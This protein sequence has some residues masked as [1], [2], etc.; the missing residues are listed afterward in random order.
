MHPQALWPVTDV[1]ST[2]MSRCQ[3]PVKRRFIAIDD[4]QAD[5]PIGE[6]SKAQAWTVQGL[7]ESTQSLFTGVLANDISVFNAQ[8]SV[9]R[10]HCFACLGKV[11]LACVGPPQFRPAGSPKPRSVLT[12]KIKN[13]SICDNK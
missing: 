8:S 11:D 2:E 9:W 7:S 10:L 13:D 12:E 4:M 5:E 6:A 3:H 1:R